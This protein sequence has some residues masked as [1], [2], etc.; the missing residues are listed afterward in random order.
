[1]AQVVSG[2]IRIHFEVEGSGTPLVLLHGLADTLDGWRDAGWV[3][4]LRN[5]HRLVLID[6]RGRPIAFPADLEKRREK[7]QRWLWDVGG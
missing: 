6:A 3:G 4:A 7:I 5:L 1:M 2:G